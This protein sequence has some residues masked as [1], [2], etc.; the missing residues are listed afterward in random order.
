MELGLSHEAI[1]QLQKEKEEMEEK[2]E[3]VTRDLERKDI[4]I[5]SILAVL[6]TCLTCCCLDI[7]YQYNA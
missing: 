2:A 1:T 6:G 4:S 7:E 5:E 3:K